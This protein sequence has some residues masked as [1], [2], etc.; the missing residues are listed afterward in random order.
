MTRK[1]VSPKATGGAGTIFEYRVAAVVYS[2]LLCGRHMPVGV[3]LPI[4]RVGLQQRIS[5]HPL[6]DIVVFA[7]PASSGI[8]MQVQV[9]SRISIQGQDNNF[10][11]LMTEAAEACQR[12]GREIAEGAML[13]G[14]AAGGPHDQVS[15]LREITEMARAQLDRTSL[16]ALLGKNISSQRFRARYNQVVAAVGE[17]A[18]GGRPADAEV[19]AHRI[20]AALYVWQVDV[21]P[22][23]HDTRTA[24]DWLSGITPADVRASDVFSHLCDLAQEYGPRAGVVDGNI[25]RRALRSRFGIRLGEP[26]VRGPAGPAIAQ[27]CQLPPVDA[28]F[29]GRD[30]ELETLRHLAAEAAEPD[31]ANGGRVAVIVGKPGVGKTTLAARAAAELREHFDEAQ[32]FADLRGVDERPADTG[33]VLGRFVRALGQDEAAL[34][35]GED[36]RSALFRSLIADRRVL[37]LLDNAASTA[38]ILNLLPGPGPSFTIVTSRNAL[39]GL[40]GAR[41]ISLDV[42]SAEEAIEFLAASAGRPELTDDP[43]VQRIVD[44]CGRL[45][46]ALR[47]VAST[48]AGWG[49][50]STT[51]LARSLQDERDRL[52]KLSPGDLGV[53]ASISLSYRRLPAQNRKVFRLLAAIPDSRFTP[54]LAAVVTGMTERNV[55][56]RLD[57][58]LAAHLLDR[59]ETDGV[60]QFHDLLR[61]YA[62]ERLAE[63]EDGANVADAELRI[64]KDILP[65]A[66]RAGRALR[67]DRLASLRPD[68]MDAAKKGLNLRWLDAEWPLIRGTL[69]LL[70]KHQLDGD[71]LA[72]IRD[73]ERYVQI[74]D[75]WASWAELSAD[76]KATAERLDEPALRLVALVMLSDARTRMHDLA[77]ATAV[78]DEIDTIMTNVSV[79]ILR[80][81]ALNARGNALRLA[82]RNDEALSCFEQARQLYGEIDQS[83]GQSICAHNIASVY[84]D[85]GHYDAAIALY[86][87]DLAFWRAAG[88]RWQEAWTLN[89]LGGAYELADSQDEAIKAHSDA[90]QIFYEF[91]DWASVSRCLNDLGIALRK[92]GRTDEALACHLADLEIESRCGDLRGV[93]MAFGALG[94]ITI[95]IDL[96]RAEAYLEKAARIAHGIGDTD[97]EGSAV[98]CRARLAIIRG[99]ADAQARIDAAL[100]IRRDSRWP[101]QYARTLMMFGALEQLPD[102]TRSAYLMEAQAVFSELG[103]QH[104]SEQAGRILMSFRTTGN[105]SEENGEGNSDH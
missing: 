46:L 61:L 15:E 57:E 79:P 99:D 43:Q 32:L 89:S 62:R 69:G 66:V 78:I 87:Q 65:P 47:V 101:R 5:G 75:L 96:N 38:Q 14:L 34:P 8:R 77:G 64:A 60:L 33:E 11:G 100:C 71:L 51:Y 37:F 56:R 74:R 84:R 73:L 10:V 22:D 105:A 29:R 36:E 82:R 23:G 52:D 72:A 18:Q 103:D 13:L 49:S 16:R 1:V 59:S 90:Y 91:G 92:H 7:A 35:A 41:Q 50:W 81:E 27:V 80:A 102:E 42:L 53:R 48:L 28:N 26:D 63:E 95:D 104:D 76:I 25:L 97:T 67:P 88:D 17:G 20:L 44:L 4:E 55:G 68:E 24:L 3:Q 39:V 40:T 98:A 70:V 9:K 12:Y 58:L 21:N 83:M 94:E 45:P 2:M 86:Q 85:L 31:A 30:G 93:A 54:R 19:L 6:D